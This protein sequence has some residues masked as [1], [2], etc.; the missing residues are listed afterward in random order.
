[1]YGQTQGF[2][3][4]CCKEPHTPSTSCRLS[5]VHAVAISSPGINCAYMHSCPLDINEN[6]N[7]WIRRLY[8]PSPRCT[9]D[10]HM[11]I[12]ALA[13]Q[14]PVARL[15][16]VAPWATVGR[17]HNPTILT[18]SSGHNNLTLVKVAQVF[19]YFKF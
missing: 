11:P 17:S 14:H 18:V 12:V 3:A 10:T 19:N 4:E 6:G 2:P 8:S 9:S 16:F 13:A 7:H 5:K 15:G 1:M